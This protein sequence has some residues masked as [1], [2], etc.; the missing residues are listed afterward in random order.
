[1]NRLSKFLLLACCCS[2]AV[3]A[4]TVDQIVARNIAARGGAR[5]IA[6]LKSQSMTGTLGFDPN[7]AEPFHAEMKRP[8]KLRQ[9]IA[10]N[11]EQFTQVA[12]AK[13]GWTLR[14]GKPPEAMS[15]AQ[16]KN[17]AGSADIQGPLFN[18]KAKGNEVV[19]AGKEKLAGR[20]AYKLVITMKDG[21]QRTDFIDAKT[22]LELKWEGVVGG[23]KMESYFRDYRKVKGLAYAFAIDSSGPNFKQKLIFDRIEVN[24]DLPDSHFTKP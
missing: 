19:L 1:M 12:D 10:V 24:L 14:P 17:L 13:E 2:L 6:A 9:E 8:G 20:D 11:P 4:Q 15:A 7:P 5:R 23:Q 18:Y 3:E 22:Y 16:V 21:T